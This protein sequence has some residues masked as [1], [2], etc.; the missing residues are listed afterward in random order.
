MTKLIWMSDPHFQAEGT[1]DGLDPRVRLDAALAHANTHYPDAACI[2]VSG[3]LVGDDIEGDYA[4]LIDRFAASALPIYPMV[5]NN[6]DRAAF[7]RAFALPKE[8][9]PGFAQYR[10]DLP[11]VAIICLDTHAPGVHSGAFCD[12]RLAWLERTLADTG[13]CIVFMHHPPLPL[14]LPRQDEIMLDDGARV[15]DVIAQAGNVRHLCMG[16]VH[17]ITCGS[18]RGVPFTSLNSLAFQAPAPRPDWDWDSFKMAPEAPSYA[19][20]D[21]TE[22]TIT[23]QFIQF[24][25]ASTGQMG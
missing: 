22:E 20:I 2:V 19:V 12:A 21:V 23:V 24:C 3:D 4:G 5:G 16:H 7:L 17:R 13:P 18:V 9:M 25:E 14:G 8:A 1:I 10:F 6:D 11:D 15:L